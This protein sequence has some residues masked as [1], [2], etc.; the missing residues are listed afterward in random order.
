[1]N[2]LRDLW[3]PQEMIVRAKRKAL[4]RAFASLF[5][6]LGFLGW[7]FG[8]QLVVGV[9]LLLFALDCYMTWRQGEVELE[10]VKFVEALDGRLN[11]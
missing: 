6:S 1:M 5:V 3:P 2:S 9:L 7:A 8:W 4:V 10:T 11:E